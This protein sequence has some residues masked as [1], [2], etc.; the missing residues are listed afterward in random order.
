M[1]LYL[2]EKEARLIKTCLLNEM[3]MLNTEN[4]K[5]ANRVC[6]R[7]DLCN[8]LQSNEQLSKNRA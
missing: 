3:A 5:L 2:N 6:D 7:I 4:K 1:R 8:K